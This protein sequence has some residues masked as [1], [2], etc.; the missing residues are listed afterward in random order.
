MDELEFYEGAS[1]GAQIDAHVQRGII[2]VSGTISESSKVISDTRISANH[3]V[4]KMLL[5]TPGAMRSD[6]VWTTA[7]KSVTLS[8]GTISGSTTATL[9]L[10]LLGGEV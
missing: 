9:T 10:A 6:W 2:T 8:S 7:S 4:V 3:V 1:T 5:G